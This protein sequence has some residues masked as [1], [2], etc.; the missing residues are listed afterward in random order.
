MIC[1]T[2]LIYERNEPKVK[3]FIN[4]YLY[5][6]IY[7]HR[8]C[9]RKRIGKVNA[10]VRRRRTNTEAH[11]IHYQRGVELIM[12]HSYARHI[13]KTGIY[14]TGTYSKDEPDERGVT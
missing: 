2:I 13:I 6:Y 1:N 11:G 12:L 7:I 4:R 8:F 3:R 14:T 10:I 9:G 5:I